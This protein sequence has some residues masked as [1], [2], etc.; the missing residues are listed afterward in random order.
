MDE[1]D[2]TGIGLTIFSILSI[3]ASGIFLGIVYYVM[4]LT[5]TNLSGIDCV[6]ENNAFVHSCQ[7][8]FAVS[9]Y[10]FLA[11]KELFIWFSYI[12]IFVLIIGLFISAY[13][14]GKNPVML[15]VSIVS[16]FVF[17]YFG[18]IISNIYR[19]LLEN[20]VFQT[21]LTP[22]PI[23]NFIMWNFPLFLFIITLISLIISIINFQKASVNTSVQ[24]DINY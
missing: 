5:K 8:L 11:L 9:L 24:G 1:A 13:R 17:T 15:G 23:Y 22:F 20:A 2:K 19:T 3:A 4:T 7:E 12:F 21:M 6:I 18:I 16:L 14:S 10:P